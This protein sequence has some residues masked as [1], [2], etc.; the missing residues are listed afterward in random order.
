MLLDPRHG[1][2]APALSLRPWSLIDLSVGI[3]A[4]LRAHKDRSPNTLCF[5]FPLVNGDNNRIFTGR[6]KEFNRTILIKPWAESLA[7]SKCSVNVH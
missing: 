4:L 3:L 6:L 1:I 5:N 2:G 7:Y